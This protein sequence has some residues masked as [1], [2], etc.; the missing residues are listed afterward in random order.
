MPGKRAFAKAKSR[1]VFAQARRPAKMVRVCCMNL[2]EQD[3]RCKVTDD[4][5]QCPRAFSSFESAKS[6]DGSLYAD[7]YAV[8][9]RA[10]RSESAALGSAV[11]QGLYRGKDSRPGNGHSAGR[12]YIDRDRS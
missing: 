3:R 11:H 1:H 4:V 10:D 5:A 2:F 6:A 7:M 12:R 9:G 8:V